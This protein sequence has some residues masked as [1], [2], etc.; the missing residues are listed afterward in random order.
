MKYQNLLV[1][2]IL[3]ASPIGLFASSSSDTDHKIEESA[4]SSYNFKTVLNDKVSIESTEGAVTLT[5][6]VQDNDAKALAEDT[7]NNIP[8]VVSVKNDIM[9]KSDYPEHSDEWVALKIRSLL[10]VKGNVSATSTTVAVL[11]GVATLGGTAN[12]S[13]QKELTE[14]YTKEVQGVKSVTNNIVVNDKPSMGDTASV[15]IDDASITSQVK[16]AL[17]SHKA[18]SALST[19]VTTTDGAVVI[20]GEAGSSA[21]EALVTKLAQ[22]VRGAKSVTNNMTIKS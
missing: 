1:A 2:L 7:V 19:K 10:L 21:E 16:F 22:D 20:T 15:T 12:T 6:T 3:V 4:T 18:T 17:L 8:G 14:I 13:A 9:I 5:G 11:D